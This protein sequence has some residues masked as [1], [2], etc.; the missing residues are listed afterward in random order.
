LKALQFHKMG[1]YNKFLGG[2]GLKLL[3]GLLSYILKAVASILS[4][5]NFYV[6]L[7]SV[8]STV[9]RFKLASTSNAACNFDS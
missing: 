6:V 3:Y 8:S 9:R 4:V 2:G 5:C 7:S 1:F